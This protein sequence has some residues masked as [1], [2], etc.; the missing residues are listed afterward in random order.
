MLFRSDREGN[1]CHIHISLRGAD[2]EAVLAGDGRHGFSPVME[3]FIAGQLA[4]LPELTLLLAPNINSYKRFADGSFAPTAVAWGL[5]NRTCGLRVVGSG[6][7]LRVENRVPGGDVNPYLA[8]AALIAAGL[9]G[10]D[11][12]LELEPA[13]E[14]NAYV[15]AR[16][17]IPA[18]LGEAAR[19]FAGSE[20]AGKAFGQDVV[21]HYARA[22]EVELEAFGKAVT[23][24]ERFRGFERL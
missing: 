19:L 4:L 18:S 2:G 20:A 7:A 16:P 11:H 14:G 5:D 8:V 21:V 24:W 9:H 15:S 1:S 10:I 23:D 12:G 22:A 17:Q 3:G 6:P 13:L